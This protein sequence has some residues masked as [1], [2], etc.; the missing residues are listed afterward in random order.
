MMMPNKKLLLAYKTI[1]RETRRQMMLLQY[2]K[3]MKMETSTIPIGMTT[4]SSYGKNRTDTLETKTTNTASN[5]QSLFDAGMPGPKELLGK[6]ITMAPNFMI[7]SNKR[8]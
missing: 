3:N 7:P 4:N 8:T 1:L 6:C 2:R 5:E